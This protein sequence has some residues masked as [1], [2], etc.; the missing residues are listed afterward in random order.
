MGQYG[1]LLKAV[2]E[3]GGE[4]CGGRPWGLPWVEWLLLVAVHYGTNL[5]MRQLPH[6]STSLPRRC[7]G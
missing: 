2:R 1:W 5:T 7:A 6:C 3:R 4:G